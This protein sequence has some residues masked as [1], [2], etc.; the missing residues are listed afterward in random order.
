[1]P[2]LPPNEGPVLGDS[3]PIDTDRR[4]Y[5]PLAHQ[6]ICDILSVVPFWASW[7]RTGLPEAIISSI[8]GFTEY[9]L[10]ESKRALAW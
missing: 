3:F 1:M 7:L 6:A 9:V 2:S 5:H 4:E 10:P 8:F